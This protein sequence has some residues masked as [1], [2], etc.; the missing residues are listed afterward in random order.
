MTEPDFSQLAA[1]HTL[2]DDPVP[3]IVD[4]LAD[5]GPAELVWRNDLGGLT[6]RIGDR[7]V[8]WSPRRTGI[9]LERERVRLDWISARHPA[10]RVVAW[11]GDEASQWLV[12][13]AVPGEPAVGDTWRARRSEAIAAIAKGL[14]AIHAVPVD[15]LP[16]TWTPGGVGRPH[17]GVA[18]RP[19]A[20][21]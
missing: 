21:R 20:D 19:P 2:G 11:G 6:F 4:E 3:A 15:D 9:D 5:G 18:R 10:P 8:K 13:Q 14:R 16:S 12:T 17:A 7:F 1:Q